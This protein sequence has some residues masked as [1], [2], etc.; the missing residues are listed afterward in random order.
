MISENPG[1]VFAKSVLQP[2]TYTQYVHSKCWRFSTRIGG[3]K[4]KAIVTGIT[5]RV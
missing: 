1:A 3:V 4:K 2:W 5:W